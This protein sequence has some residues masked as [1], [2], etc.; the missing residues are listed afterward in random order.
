MNKIMYWPGFARKDDE[1]LYLL[2]E[3]KKRGLDVTKFPYN[4]DYGNIIPHEWNTL[5][6][7]DFDW[8]LGISL[9]ASVMVYSLRFL[10][11]EYYPK[12]ITIINPFYSRSELAKKNGFDMSNQMD[13]KLDQIVKNIDKIELVSSLYDEKI[14]MNDGVRVVCNFEATNRSIIFVK[15]NHGIDDSYVQTELAHILIPN[16]DY[17]E[18][19]KYCDIYFN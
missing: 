1:L 19:Y 8:W 2:S 7:W 3:V 13:F 10:P 14:R 15:S 6:E 5:V 16:K 11:I 9:G 4:Y 17:N 18:K 12:R